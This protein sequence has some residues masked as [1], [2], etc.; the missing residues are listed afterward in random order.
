LRTDPRP[1]R[2]RSRGQPQDARRHRGQRPRCLPPICGASPGGCGR[3]VA[4]SHSTFPGG[5][6]SRPAF[7]FQE[8]KR[9][10]RTEPP[11][12]HRQMIESPHIEKLKLVRKLRERKQ[13]EREGAFVSEGEDLV[14]A[15]LAAG[16]E[17]RFLLT[18]AGSDLGG[19]EVE[20]ELLAEASSLGSGTRAI[21]VWP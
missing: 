7:L 15:G 5:P 10:T 16:V 1:Q 3:L 21:A 20:P 18:S 11:T 17:P 4:A 6:F 14:E 13:R 2:G 12:P 9:T 8:K 19:E